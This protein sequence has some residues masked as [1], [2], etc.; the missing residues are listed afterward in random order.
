MF[1]LVLKLPLV[2]SDRKFEVFRVHSFPMQV[3][4]G[5]FVRLQIQNGLLAVN[6][7]HHTYMTLT[8]VE[9]NQCTGS[10]NIRV[11]KADKGIRNRI[12]DVTRV[13]LIC[14]NMQML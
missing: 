6:E 9:L 8:K 13:R 1:V 12:T 5:T 14:I 7:M 10:G 4:N 11:C 3:S 2:T